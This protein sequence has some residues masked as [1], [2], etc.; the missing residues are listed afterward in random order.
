VIL[1]HHLLLPKSIAMPLLTRTAISRV[2]SLKNSS[3][4]ERRMHLKISSMATLRCWSKV[5]T[6]IDSKVFAAN[7]NARSSFRLSATHAYSTLSTRRTT[8]TMGCI[9][10]THLRWFHVTTTLSAKQ[11]WSSSQQQQQP[12]NQQPSSTVRVAG[13]VALIA[14]TFATW[15]VSDWVLQDKQQQKNEDLRK[16]FLRRQQKAWNEHTKNN[17]HANE[18]D[19]DHS[20]LETPLFYCVIR[21]AQGWNVTHCLTGAK[22]GDV[23]EV[24][25]E[26]TGPKGEYNLCRLPARNG[27]DDTIGLFP[28]RWLQR[29]ENYQ[30]MVVEHQ[31]AAHNA[32]E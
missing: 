1:G 9:S 5:V 31:N 22:V 28:I 18:E 27:M 23:V 3:L 17:T 13:P 11:H 21:R 16:E 29:L 4:V 24:L 25:Q 20:S 26:R 2:K 19:N 7:R 6:A 14:L 10:Q 15:G 30:G 8:T 32:E 12:K